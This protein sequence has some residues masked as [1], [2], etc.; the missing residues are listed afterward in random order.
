MLATFDNVYKAGGLTTSENVAFEDSRD[1]WAYDVMS[2]PDPTYDEAHYR[3]NDLGN[4]LSRP[5]N[6]A[7]YS[8]AVGGTLETSF[9][10]WT[11]FLENAQVLARLQ[12]YN[13]L[14]C[15]LRVK[16][17]VNGNAFL[18]GRLIAAYHPLST[19]DQV[20]SLTLSSDISIVQMSQRPHIYLDPTKSQGGTMLL[21]F[22]FHKNWFSLPLKDYS[23]IGTMQLWSFGTLKHA[24]D[25]TET[26]TVSIFAWAEDVTLCV[27]TT[28]L[29]S[30]ADEYG[31]GIISKPAS[32]VAQA[33]G[34]LTKVPY[35]GPYAKATQKVANAISGVAR[36]FGFSRLPVISEII[37][38]KP[39]LMGNLSATDQDETVTRL[40]V[41][42]KQELTVDPRTV[43]L[44]QTDEMT[45]RHICSK[46]SYYT[47]FSWPTSATTDQILFSTA[48]SPCMFR[49]TGTTYD[50]TA[51][52]FAAQPF[53][54]WSGT[55][56][57]RF[58][59]VASE[60][61]KGRIRILYDPLAYTGAASTDYNTAYN[62]VV[63]LSLERDFEI[64]VSWAQEIPYKT[65]S[66][67]IS[68]GELFTASGSPL[69]AN[70]DEYNGTLTVIVV[71]TLTTPNSVANNDITVNV[72]ISGGDDLEFCAPTNDNI[73]KL[74][75]FVSQSDDANDQDASIPLGA[76]PV[77]AIGVE[78]S[79][80][81]SKKNMVFFGEHIASFR[82][83]LRRYWYHSGRSIKALAETAFESWI[84]TYN[85]FP[86]YRGYDPSGI[87]ATTGTPYNYSNTVLLTYL[88]P[89]YVAYRG[90][91]R[92]KYLAMS[93]RSQ[94]ATVSVTRSPDSGAFLNNIVPYVQLSDTSQSQFGYTMINGF[95]DMGPGAYISPI[96][97]QPCGEVELPFYSPY[98]FAFSRTISNNN[99]IE[100]DHT[101][102]M[103][104]RAT[105]IVQSS[106]D[107]VHSVQRYVS[108]GE[109]FSLFFFLNAPR[110]YAY[111]TPE[112]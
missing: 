91:I 36:I 21:P 32:A 74:S 46:E 107:E 60:Y 49:E 50:Q 92:Y 69:P 33:A 85:N 27:P 16:F 81:S 103:G 66:P 61:H 55:L 100:E 8:W 19:Y 22:F 75:Y 78:R 109:D 54:Y 1:Q 14:R 53:Q 65:V 101:N 97:Q 90:G 79:E 106:T 7:T 98:R 99:G 26:V 88:A 57:Y 43:G 77:M 37:N 25:A 15:K 87:D 62:R 3:D 51:V 39:C 31:E 41:D 34:S 105:F 20:D 67:L 44:H 10:P 23:T 84:L 48:V 6:I 76:Q 11:L 4:F 56:K 35:I 102:R 13:L 112:P 58:Q 40:T 95:L 45:I 24:N 71:N 80:M 5:V 108:V 59:I 29:I 28:N 30:Q 68:S 96:F 47:Q 93:T 82:Q 2:Q 18:Y 104:H 110:V 70:I 63:D 73:R 94:R 86:N 64:D 111:D 42:S 12:H 52:C 89:A 72:F 17:V 83:L 38:Y 9:D